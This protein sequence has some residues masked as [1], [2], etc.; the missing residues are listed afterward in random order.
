MVLPTEQVVVLLVVGKRTN[1]PM[2]AAHASEDIVTGRKGVGER[3]RS[4]GSRKAHI[5]PPQ[6][7]KKHSKHCGGN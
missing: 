6:Q 1:L 2:D 4:V 3:R 7:K 5:R